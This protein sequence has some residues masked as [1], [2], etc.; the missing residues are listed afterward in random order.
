MTVLT[1]LVRHGEDQRLSRDPKTGAARHTLGPV[2]REM[3]LQICSDYPG[4]PDPRTLTLSE[5]RFFYEGMRPE[6]QRRTKPAGQPRLP[7]IPRARS[8]RW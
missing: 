7:R 5:I 2:Y 1:P 3:L 4:L 6:L 8:G